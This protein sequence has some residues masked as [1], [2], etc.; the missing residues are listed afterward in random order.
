MLI[1]LPFCVQA[2]DALLSDA[3]PRPL[4]IE[5]GAPFCDNMVLQREMPVPVWGWSRPGTRV[6]VEFS[7][8]QKTSIAGTRG[9]W[10]VELDPLQASFVPAEMVI[11]EDTGKKRTLQNILVGEVWLASGQSN[12]QWK[13]AKSKCAK[14][15][16]E[17]ATKTEGKIAPIREFQVTSVT[18]QLH[19]I[20]KAT[21]VWN[22]GNY[23]EYSAIAFAFAH[24]LYEELHV[25]IGILNC[26]FSQKI[27]RAH[28]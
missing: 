1:W 22:D 7:N 21:G 2:T 8:Q 19:P 28:V 17:L 20:K 16:Q 25:P 3:D 24:K 23:V 27:G 11:V 18:S 10:M 14:L 15:A 12:M 5:V 9:E 13:V 6:T 4:E 26:S